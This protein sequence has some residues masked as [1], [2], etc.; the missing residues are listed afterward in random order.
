MARIEV[1]ADIMCPFTH[2][3][4]RRL[5]AARD[6]AGVAAGVRVRAWPLEWINGAPLAAELVGREVRALQEGVAPELFAG[7]DAGRFPT[8]SIPGFGLADAAYS[9][10]DAVGEAVSVALRDALFED[11][12]DVSDERVLTGIAARFGIARPDP[13]VVAVAVRSDWHTGRTRGVLGSPHFFVAD[14]DWFC[15]SLVIEHEGDDL[16]ARVADEQ[17]RDFYGAA[18]G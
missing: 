11:G 8:T 10:G 2:V 12:L 1:F 7:F 5:I 13:A 17:M 9:V 18:L 3:G 14:R 15:P 16:V 4:L 6:A